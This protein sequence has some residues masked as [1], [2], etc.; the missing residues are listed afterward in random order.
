MLTL[1][2]FYFKGNTFRLLIDEKAALRPRY[3][4]EDALKGTP[5]PGT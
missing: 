3:K 5:I 4:V 2:L 1:S